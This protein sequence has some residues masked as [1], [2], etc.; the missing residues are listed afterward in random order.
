[1]YEREKKVGI[2]S[3]AGGILALLMH[4]RI[5]LADVCHDL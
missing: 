2:P 4:D 1:M 5:P 3:S